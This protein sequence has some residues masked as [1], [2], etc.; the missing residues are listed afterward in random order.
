MEH[1]VG[2]VYAELISPG[3]N[4]GIIATPKGTVIVD[5]PLLSKQAKVI[6]DALSKEKQAPADRPVRRGGLCVRPKGV[7]AL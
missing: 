1:V 3:C 7:L 2:N 5:T 4:I 6:S